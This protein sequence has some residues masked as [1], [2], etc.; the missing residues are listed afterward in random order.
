[1]SH[2]ALPWKSLSDSVELPVYLER[3]FNEKASMTTFLRS[4]GSELTVS[5]LYQGMTTLDDDMC[6][7]L[8]LAN[9]T[10][11]LV[12]QVILSIDGNPALLGLCMMDENTYSR[13]P[14]VKTLGESA[15]GERLFQSPDL[16]R[17]HI[18]VVLL[19]PDSQYHAIL[20]P[21]CDVSN[22]RLWARR[23]YLQDN[24]FHVGVIDVCLPWLSEL[25]TRTQSEMQ[26]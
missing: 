8:Q 13:L 24:T 5:L 9:N 11:A 12:R 19:P 17:T 4:L 14:W 15:I 2:S 16:S 7:F 3:P 25:L 26:V 1:M 22:Q 23:S 6:Q 18:E 21:I 10:Q 20:S